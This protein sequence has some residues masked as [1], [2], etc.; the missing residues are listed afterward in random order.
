M[1]ENSAIEWT[2]HTASP[3]HGCSERTFDGE[4]PDHPGCDHCY[5]RQFSLRNPAVLGVWGEQGVRVKSKSFVK[6][7]RSWQRSAARRGV[8]ESVFPSI[9]DPFEDRPEL[10]PWRREMFQV[11]DECPNLRLLL[12]TKRPENIGRMW[13]A[14]FPGGYVPEAGRMNREELRPN[15]WLGTSISNQATADR[16]IPELLKCRDLSP[17][18]FLSAEPLLGPIDL[19]L[20][21]AT[22]QCCKRLPSR[23]INLRRQVTGD[24]PFSSLRVMPGTYRAES[25]RHG[26]LSVRCEGGQPLGIMPSEMN[27]M[28]PI[29]WV[30]CGG[31][32][33][34]WARPMHRIWARFLRDQCVA[35]GVPFFFKQ[36]GEWQN[37]S[38]PGDVD[39]AIVL[40]N[41]EW[42]RN[43]TPEEIRAK[44]RDLG[45]RWNELD[46]ISM[47]KVGKVAAGRLLDG[48]EWSQ[49]PLVASSI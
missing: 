19:G 1:A 28:G 32:S 41:G 47:A 25:N 34:Y 46:P 44:D 36:W 48:Q 38:S 16:M 4:I 26:A 43:P 11:I 42:L 27:V 29:D 49:F 31:E 30:I 23:W 12:L 21:T 5:A 17:V 33:G 2:D 3:W 9:C 10:E 15:V 22:C 8:I 35:A 37:G 18:L 40:S 7:L 6:N 45:F 24:S 39:H 13:P 14:Y 20:S